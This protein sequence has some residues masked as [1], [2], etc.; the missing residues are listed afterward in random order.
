MVLV[1]P[2]AKGFGEQLGE[3]LGGAANQASQL[4]A[5]KIMDKSKDEK[6]S[7]AFKKLTGVDLS[8][9]SPEAKQEFVKQFAKTQA[10][11]ALISKMFGSQKQPSTASQLQSGGEELSSSDISGE[12]K[13][14]FDIGDLNSEER[15]KLSMIN[16]T[17]ARQATEEEKLKDKRKTEEQKK[18]EFG[19]K[20]TKKYGEEIQ[21]AAANANEI[22]FATGVIRNAIRSGKTGASAQNLAYAYLS[23][24]KS[25]IAGLFQSK[26]AGQFNVAMKTLAS[27]FKKIMGAKPTEREFFWYE[28]IL[29]GLLKAAPTNEAILDYFDHLADLD[30][31]SQEVYDEIIDKN[32]GYRPIDIDKKVRDQ[33]K[34]FLNEAINEGYALSGEF[35][36]SPKSGK[37]KAAEKTTFTEMPPA[38]P[39]NKGKILTDHDSGQR[40][41]SDG[42]EW[43]PLNG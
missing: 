2:K 17:L 37:G 23:D 9:L 31:K 4:F 13:E 42:K 12:A 11:E 26:E 43:I 40:F 14:G 7:A 25:P 22:K 32:S 16:P 6:Q 21:S 15:I 5:Q 36:S 18:I 28:N 19:H 39:S 34:P 38:N 41:R 27:G 1:L 24:S 30:I 33:M 35:E 10:Q 8:G 20:E 29:P 3:A